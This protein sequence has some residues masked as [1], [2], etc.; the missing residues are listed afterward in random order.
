M[1]HLQKMNTF[2]A[3]IFLISNMILIEFS[4]NNKSEVKNQLK[5]LTIYLKTKGG[6]C[7]HE[8]VQH[9]SNYFIYC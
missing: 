6:V 4:D 7:F 1:N 5:I 2:K 3:K 9:T 8:N